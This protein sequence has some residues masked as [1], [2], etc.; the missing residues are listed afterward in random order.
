MAT[1]TNAREQLIAFTIA[2]GWEL[3]PNQTMWSDY[4]RVISPDRTRIQNPHAFRKADGVGGFWTIELDYSVQAEWGKTDNRLRSLR[5][6]HVNAEGGL[7]ALGSRH[8]N[9]SVNL[10]PKYADSWR[11]L[12]SQVWQVT[13]GVTGSNTLRQ[14][15]ELVIVDPALVLWLAEEANYQRTLEIE[16]ER[17]R[18]AERTAARKRPLAITIELA[19][20]RTL[21]HEL[22]SATSELRTADGLTDLP[23]AVAKAEAAIAAIRAALATQDAEVVV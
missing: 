6:A 23:A 1:K 2:Q 22:S 13:H 5:L 21:A 10:D 18:T 4:G 20:F 15:A 11:T 16:A 8:Y 17:K 9:L 12:N 7:Q 14:R 19:E 3:D